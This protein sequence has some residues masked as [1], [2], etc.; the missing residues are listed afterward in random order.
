ME[1]QASPSAKN[2]LRILFTDSLHRHLLDLIEL[3]I[4]KQFPLI[5]AAKSGMIVRDNLTWPEGSSWSA[6]LGG[7]K[8]I[9]YIHLGSPFSLMRDRIDKY[10]SFLTIP[11]PCERSLRYTV[12]HSA[13]FTSSSTLISPPNC[14]FFPDPGHL[15]PESKNWRSPSPQKKVRLQEWTG[16]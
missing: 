4:R 8:I 16:R 9:P 13:T 7:R 2:T 10:L 1:C 5:S 6:S 14:N 12:Y 3:F 15:L 11:N